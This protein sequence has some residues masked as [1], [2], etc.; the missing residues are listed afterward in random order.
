MRQGRPARIQAIF[1]H[2]VIFTCMADH[3]VQVRQ[4]DFVLNMPLST[5][6][7]CRKQ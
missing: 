1:P 4:C 7:E 3:I 2:P 6:A 5:L